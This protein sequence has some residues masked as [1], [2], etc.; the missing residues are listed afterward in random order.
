MKRIFNN[1]KN[2]KYEEENDV[3]KKGRMSNDA[4]VVGDSNSTYEGMN[5]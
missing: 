2:R 5:T 3:K 1:Y 4:W